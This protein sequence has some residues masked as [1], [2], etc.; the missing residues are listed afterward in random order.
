MTDSPWK[1]LHY[2]THIPDLLW[3]SWIPRQGLRRLFLC[4]PHKP[5]CR[6]PV[7]LG[8]HITVTKRTLLLCMNE[9]HNN[10]LTVHWFSTNVATQHRLPGDGLVAPHVSVLLFIS[11]S[12]TTPSPPCQR[13]TVSPGL[14]TSPTPELQLC[15][16]THPQTEGDPNW[17]AFVWPLE[18]FFS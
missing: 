17:N 18:I 6:L 2:A 11:L 16:W 8:K 12:L 3:H 7:P 1:S 10:Q 14:P 5:T 13:K 4:S 15:P 9:Q